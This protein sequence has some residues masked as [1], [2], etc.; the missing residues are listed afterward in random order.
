[1]AV[2]VFAGCG[3]VNG[4]EDE[5]GGVFS[6]DATVIIRTDTGVVHSSGILVDN[7]IDG[8]TMSVR[9]SSSLKAPDG[10]ALSDRNIRFLGIDAPEVAHGSNPAD[11]WGDESAAFARTMLIGKFVTLEYDESHELRDTFG[12]LLAYIRLDDDRVANEVLLRE[13]MAR[14]FRAFPHRETTAYNALEQEARSAN[15]G[16]WTCQ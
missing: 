6:R 14:S 16:M 2:A 4:G 15:R 7:V 13:G 1:L 5:D 3:E 10:I 12:R 11:C 9:A 8:D